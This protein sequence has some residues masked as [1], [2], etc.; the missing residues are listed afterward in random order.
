MTDKSPPNDVPDEVPPENEDPMAASPLDDVDL[1]DEPDSPILTP[2]QGDES[3]SVRMNSRSEQLRLRFG[4][5]EA[6]WDFL[7]SVLL[8]LPYPVFVVLMVTQTFDG[9]AFLFLT[10]VYSLFA[11]ALN[12]YL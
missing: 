7:V 9:L 5:S 12:F 1:D 3:D 6:Q 8:F 4:L 2:F 10:L 11:V